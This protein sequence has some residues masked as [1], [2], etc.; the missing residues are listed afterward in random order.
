MTRMC[1][2]ILAALFCAA[3]MGG[4][5]LAAST[6]APLAPLPTPSAASGAQTPASTALPTERPLATEAPA[7][8]PQAEPA[9][10]R[11]QASPSA[12]EAPTQ[13]SEASPTQ[14]PYPTPTPG[15]ALTPTASAA[16]EASATPGAS[17]APEDIFA[18]LPADMPTVPPLAT[19]EPG[20]L[21]GVR[22]G[23]DPGHQAQGNSEQ[24]AVAPGSS[25]TKAKVSTGT[26]GRFTGVPE[27]EV[28]LAVSLKLRDALEALGCEVY[29]TRETADVDIS[30]QERAI[31]MNELGVDLVLRIHCNGSTNESAQGIGLYIRDTGTNADE[32]L[33]AAE[34]LLPAM[35]EATGAESDGIFRRD[36]YTGLNWSEVPS[37]LVEMG[38]M[39]NEEEDHKLNDPA[40][41][42][43]LVEGMV[44]GV[45]AYMGR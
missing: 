41:Q 22:I 38:F 8:T 37:I 16:A 35:V 2:W 12:T 4:M 7:E 15:I 44:E 45:C 18:S 24:E 11:P 1:K 30:N 39:T 26:Y 42:D 34:A 23:I 43:Q 19:R 32:C 40:Y 14:T 25:E 5:A 31:M 10:A 3:L 20:R 36:T 29:M 6:A 17:A 9:P 27:H 13:A 33:R 21:T 28:N